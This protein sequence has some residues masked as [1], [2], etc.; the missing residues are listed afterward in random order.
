MIWRHGVLGPHTL[1]PDEVAEDVGDAA[2]IDETHKHV[3]AFR[4]TV[5]GVWALFSPPADG[6]VWDTSDSG[7]GE[8]G[9]NCRG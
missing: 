2:E 8:N 1:A 9:E 7:A 6:P 4:E 3:V 5:A